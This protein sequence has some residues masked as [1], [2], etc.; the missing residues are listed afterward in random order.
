MAATMPL[1]DRSIRL[2]ALASMPET[3][4][5][6]R[7]REIASAALAPRNG[8]AAGIQA[9]IATYETRFHMTSADM[10]ARFRRGDLK[11]TE[12]MS[13]WLMLLRASGAAIR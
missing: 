6:A 10:V 8:Q 7:L 4:R 11:D 9:R 3:E 1:T 2:S 5:A 13:G 12:D